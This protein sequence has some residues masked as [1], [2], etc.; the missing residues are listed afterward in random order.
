MKFRN[1]TRGRA[2]GVAMI[3]MVVVCCS[4][5][6]QKPLVWGTIQEAVEEGDLQDV[7]RHLDRGEALN[8]KNT[9]GETLLFIAINKGNKE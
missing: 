9:D 4:G 8:A 2:L 6:D 1:I 3:L 7:K 5:Q